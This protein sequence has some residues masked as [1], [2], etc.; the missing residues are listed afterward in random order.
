MGYPFIPLIL[1]PI[2]IGY[3]LYL[4]LV[5]KDTKKF[6]SVIVPGLFFIALW[7]VIYYFLLK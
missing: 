5:K 2:F 3:V 1:I 4:L 6:R 7:V